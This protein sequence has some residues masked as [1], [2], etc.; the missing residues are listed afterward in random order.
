MEDR[1]LADFSLRKAQKGRRTT[2]YERNILKN[3]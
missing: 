1:E 3:R 2:A